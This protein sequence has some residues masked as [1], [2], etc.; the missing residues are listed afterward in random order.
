MAAVFLFGFSS[1]SGCITNK[2]LD[3]RRERET[4]VKEAVNF[5]SLAAVRSA[6]V[7]ADGEV[8]ACVEFRDSLGK[9]TETYTINIS[10]APRLGRT[11]ADFMPAGSGW[12]EGEHG[13]GSAADLDWRLY[14]LQEAQKGCGKAAG[15][16]P[17]SVSQLKI[18]TVQIR[19]EDQSH[20][21][22]MFLP[23]D[24]GETSESRLIEVSFL[25]TES[26]GA[27]DVLLVYLP[28]AKDAGQTKA[29]GVAGAFE[30]GSEWV[31]P[32][33]V[34]VAPAVAADTAVSYMIIMLG[35][36]VWEYWGYR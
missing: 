7:V 14:P 18:D 20:L 24:E 2:V 8:F 36:R 3:L 13:S 25:E 17:F 10:Q 12:A 6:H 11:Y 33:T 5:W 34:L 9:A 22:G 26:S 29:I 28:P 19:R 4:R 27:R 30:P 16:S 1:L 23:P 15:E 21:P 31:N 35:G 32:Y